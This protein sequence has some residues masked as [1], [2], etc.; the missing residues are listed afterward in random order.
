MCL[1]RFIGPS[2][3]L[4]AA[5]KDKSRIEKAPMHKDSTLSPTKPIVLTIPAECTFQKSQVVN[6]DEVCE[7]WTL[8][9]SS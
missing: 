9:G 1:D 5:I 7:H 3:M 2:N 8:A 6:M 4:Y